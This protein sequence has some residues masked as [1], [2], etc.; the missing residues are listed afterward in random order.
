MD[1]AREFQKLKG[2]NLG[3]YSESRGILKVREAI[4][5]HMR[6]R[7]GIKEINLN[8]MY[9]CNGGMNAYDYAV[10][11]MYNPGEKVKGLR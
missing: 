7:E 3:A 6:N 11:L 2:F 10:N 5:E 8:D 9:L 1:K 4:G